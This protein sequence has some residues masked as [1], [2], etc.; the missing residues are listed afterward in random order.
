MRQVQHKPSEHQ[1]HHGELVEFV[2]CRRLELVPSRVLHQ[3]AVRALPCFFPQSPLLG[4]LRV[5]LATCKSTN[6]RSSS[7]HVRTMRCT[8]LPCV[9][10]QHDTTLIGVQVSQ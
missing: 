5:L 8:C 2:R 10:R 4:R 1:L 7:P 9:G 3:W 6:A